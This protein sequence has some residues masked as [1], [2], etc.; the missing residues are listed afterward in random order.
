MKTLPPRLAGVLA[1]LCLVLFA[2]SSLAQDKA[3]QIDAL[4]TK[5]HETGQFNGAVL[6]AERGR[7]ILKKGYGEADMAWHVPNTPDTRFRIGSVTKQ[8]TATLILQLVEE[9]KLRLDDPVAK[10]LP[11]YPKPQGEQVTIHHLLT[12]T[13][14]IPN[15]T[16]L[17]GFMQNE[18]RN[19]YPPDSLLTVFAHLDLEF[20]PG[21]RFNYSNSGYV[22]LGVVIEHVA[23]QPYDEVLHA[24]IL[25]P[26]GLADTGY[27][28]HRAVVE[29]RAVGYARTP[30]GYEHAAY[31]DTS[32][33][34]AAGMMYSTVEDL[35]KWDQALYG[36]GI[37]QNPE[38]K[39][40]MFTPFLNDYGYG[41]AIHEMPVGETGRQVKVVEHAG[42]IFGFSTGFWRLIDDRSTIVVMDNTQGNQVGAIGQGIVNLLYGA[43]AAAPRVPI[44]DVLRKTLDAEG[45]EAAR[46]QYHLLKS[47]Q[48]DAYDFRENQLN[49]L[50]YFYLRRGD[51]ETAIALFQ[52]N[53]EAFPEG[54]NTY[55][56]LGEGYME[57]GDHEKA[58]A[59]YKKSLALNPGND[60]AREMLAKMGAEA[61]VAAEMTLPPDVLE[62]YVGTYRLQPGFEIAVTREGGQLYAQATGQPRFEIFPQSETKFYLKVVAAQIEFHTGD[63]GTAQSLTLFQGGREM[64]APKVE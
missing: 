30:G 23:G 40:Q 25:D 17:P 44:A 63:D 60:N 21:T 3:A 55:D 22:L 59:N 51:A 12:H 41:W 49:N 4:L 18:V 24:R 9:G 31:L 43:E 36:D 33:P 48:P 32:I 34:Y 26:L 62:R 46:A 42:G 19:P 1:L 35:F 7:V 13:S 58:I 57:A 2:P 38:T 39:T 5:Y 52:L 20:E 16:N 54:F 28:H 50:G 27:D 14:G 11:D 64:P 29:R 6:V 37:F 10:V 53:V 8:F 47:S 56:S 15:M 45:V 61:E